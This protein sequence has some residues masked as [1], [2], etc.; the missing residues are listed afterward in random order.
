[1]RLLCLHGM[2]TNRNI[3][4]LQLAKLQER[5]GYEHDF[6]YLQGHR[7]CRAAVGMDCGFEA[8]GL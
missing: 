5:L 2:G 3:L 8:C 6:V 1:M 4:E 7:E